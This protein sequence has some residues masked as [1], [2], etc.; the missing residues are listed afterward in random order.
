[1]NQQPG[2]CGK[3]VCQALK[4]KKRIAN[5][6]KGHCSSEMDTQ[7]YQM[8]TVLVVCTTVGWIKNS[9]NY[10]LCINEKTFY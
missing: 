2:T 3:E 1:M 5:V 9:Q 4:Y 6:K 7:K 10:N 8:S